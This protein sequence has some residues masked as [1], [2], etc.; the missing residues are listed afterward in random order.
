MT[1]PGRACPIVC[2][3]RVLRGGSWNNNPRNLRAGYRNGNDPGNR[4][5]NIGFRV[6]RTLLRQSRPDHG[7]G[8]RV[9]E[10]PR[11]V[12]VKRPAAWVVGQARC[13]SWPKGDGCRVLP[14]RTG[15]AVS[16]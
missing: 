5:N 13:P 11:S 3:S 14:A 1:R 9:L 8:G 16:E 10:R 4:N 15:A 2:S 12:M 6:A 7:R